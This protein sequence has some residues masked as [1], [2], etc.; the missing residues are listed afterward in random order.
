MGIC[1]PRDRLQVN[2]VVHHL[3]RYPALEGLRHSFRFFSVLANSEGLPQRQILAFL[4]LSPYE[5]DLLVCA[6]SLPAFVVE[7]EVHWSNFLVLWLLE[8]RAFLFKR[9]R[10]VYVEPLMLKLIKNTVQPLLF[11]WDYLPRLQISRRVA[12]RESEVLVSRRY[13]ES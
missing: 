12:L 7:A 6:V 10:L 11:R 3:T 1:D 9:M 5:T 8:I 4:T 13:S 2:S